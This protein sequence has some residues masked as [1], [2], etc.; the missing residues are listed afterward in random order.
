MTGTKRAREGSGRVKLEEVASAA[1]VS[2]A[3]VSRVFNEPEK[4]SEAIRERVKE[5]ARALNWI[6][7]A[8][9]RALASSRTHI[10]G[11]IIPTLDNEIFAHQVGGMQAV[12]SN[13]GYTLFLG[14]SNYDPL[15]G[16]RQ[17]EA[18]LARGVEAIALVGESHPAELFVALKARN[19]PYVVTYSYSTRSEHPCIGFDN[20]AAFM[21]MTNH[22]LSLGHRRFACIFQPVANNDRVAAR[23]A[24][25]REA[26]AAAGLQLADEDLLIGPSTL[27][28]GAESFSHL[29]TRDGKARPTAIVCGNDNIALGALMAANALGLNAPKDFSITGFDDLA[30]SSRF[31]PRLTTMK[32]DNQAIGTMA[33]NQLLA[34]VAGQQASPK[35]EEVVPVLQVRDSSGPRP[36]ERG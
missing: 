28:F 12:F 29:M 32:V 20:R 17:A 10:M 6:P 7:N 25:V 34:V 23:L 8:A 30:I 14:C 24:G 35:S 33:A 18:M 3:T 21:R 16:L 4:V 1:N 11:A 31:T 22:L 2:T 9:G 36:E 13:A 27:E 5:A 19:I 26:L 15:E